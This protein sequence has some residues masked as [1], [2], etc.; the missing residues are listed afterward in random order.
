MSKNK[1]Y[2]RQII[3][4]NKCDNYGIPATRTQINNNW[5]DELSEKH[6][7]RIRINREVFRGK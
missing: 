2:R 5:R 7:R 6:A 3:R 1:N 4:G